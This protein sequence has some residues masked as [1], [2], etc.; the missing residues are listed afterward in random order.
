MLLKEDV[1]AF[2]Y[3]TCHLIVSLH[4]HAHDKQHTLLLYV[5]GCL[6]RNTYL[7]LSHNR[8]QHL[9]PSPS[10]HAAPGRHPTPHTHLH[11]NTDGIYQPRQHIGACHTR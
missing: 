5:L 1:V 9:F 8:K 11:W 4:T 2:K 6:H 3:H 7:R 10:W